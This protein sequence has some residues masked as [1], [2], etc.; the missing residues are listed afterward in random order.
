MHSKKK[1]IKKKI[2]LFRTRQ[3][4]GNPQGKE[5]PSLRDNAEN[6]QVPCHRQLAPKMA[7]N[8]FAGQNIIKPPSTL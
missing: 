6:S 4:Q 7:E 1:K 5:D 3:I 8:D 2:D